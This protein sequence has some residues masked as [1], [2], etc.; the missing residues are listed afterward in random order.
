MIWPF[1]RDRM[2]PAEKAEVY[3]FAKGRPGSVFMGYDPK[4]RRFFAKIDGRESTDPMSPMAAFHKAVHE[5]ERVEV[6]TLLSGPERV[7]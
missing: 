3:A 5:A 4:E 2:K 1:A 7:A 6:V